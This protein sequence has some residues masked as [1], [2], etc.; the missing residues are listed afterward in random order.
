[1]KPK[2]ICL[3]IWSFSLPLAILIIVFWSKGFLP[4]LQNSNLISD[5]YFQYIDFFAWLRNTILADGVIPAYSF[6]IS[7][8]NPTIALLAYYLAS[9]FNWLV[10]L[11]DQSMLPYCIL[12]ITS[13][14]IG[15]SG[16]TMCVYVRRR[17]PSLPNVYVLMASLG[18]SLMYYN[19]AQATN[20][21]WLDGVYVLP[22][23]LLGAYHVLKGRSGI[24]LAIT[25]CLSILFNWYTAYMN[26]LFAF[27]Y[28]F[29]EC[30][31]ENKV[32]K[33]IGK[34]TF[35]FCTYEIIG[36]LL[37][38]FV[39]IPVIFGMIQ[40]K[41]NVETSGIFNF[42]FR[43]NLLEIL[44]GFFPGAVYDDANQTL[45]LFCGSVFFFF[46]ILFFIHSK[47][48]KREKIVTAA[49]FFFM[50]LSTQILALENIWNG[51]RYASSYYCRFSYIVTFL[52]IFIGLKGIE[53][54]LLPKCL[55]KKSLLYLLIIV[56][57][58]YS[59]FKLNLP[60][61][62]GRYSGYIYILLLYA[63]WISVH[64]KKF[65]GQLLLAIT[66]IELLFNGVLVYRMGETSI[67][68]HVSYTEQ[69]NEQIQLLRK[70]DDFKANGNFY[71]L[72]ET[73]NRQ[74]VQNGIAAAYND[75][76]AYGYYGLA[77]YASTTGSG[78]VN[79]ATDLGYYNGEAFIIPYS[80]A[81]LPSDS[82]LGIRYVMSQRDIPG[83][84]MVN[85]ISHGLNGKNV[86]KNPYALPIGLKTSKKIL[87]ETSQENP[88][89]FQNEIYSKILGR[90][91]EL[92]KP[93]VYSKQ[94]D[95]NSILINV[96]K[97]G[98][99][100]DLLYVSADTVS[101]DLPV[102][103][104][105]VYRTNYQKWLSYR[106]MC[107]GYG[108]TGHALRFDN[109]SEGVE[110]FNEHVYYLDMEL[111]SQVISELK[112]TG[113]NPEKVENGLVEGTYISEEDS[114]L[115]LSIPYDSGW[116]IKVND[117]PVTAQKGMN[118]FLTIPVK[119]GENKIQCVY[120]TPG[121]S[122]GIM[123]SGIGLL[124][125]I[126]MEVYQRKQIKERNVKV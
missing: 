72:E 30:V 44:E 29:Y 47:I 38:C 53:N 99:S 87:T 19:I 27:L 110:D 39:F 125:L 78:P 8:G 116:K 49:V 114:C 67:Q 28:F 109:V 105:G 17:F 82:L 120:K 60:E 61:G 7:L 34:K 45:F 104:D 124:G 91:C 113:F 119:K 63:I 20:I 52:V 80:E 70:F 69:Q 23:I 1:M 16:L 117:L 18:Y 98:N 102:Y 46:L 108:Q 111:F 76:M 51:F 54:L 89:L 40:S 112:A 64:E 41:A 11:F 48:N 56:T 83:Y 115:L 122:L 71:R 121:V 50:L 85:A 77:N 95:G 126:F 65:A 86:Y 103:I 90:S 84:Q 32:I 26:C 101:Y 88:F 31:L 2:S 21:M 37:S 9:P 25:I 106:T 107:L 97:T 15:L 57:C 10:L 79:F 42:K 24:L 35:I 100:Q 123:V 43:G 81:I 4:V 66:G 55:S 74:M 118:S 6:S 92:F 73:M 13:L 59:A 3:Y 93:A 62:V 96:E 94:K 14:K 22:L 5:L 36:V 12:L 33:D 68:Q 75:S 58:I